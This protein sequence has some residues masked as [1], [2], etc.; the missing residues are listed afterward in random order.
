MTSKRK[1]RFIATNRVW[2]DRA[3]RF[4]TLLQHLKPRKGEFEIDSINSVEDTKG[5][6]GERG[7]LI[8]TNLR[9]IWACH[10][11]PTTNLSVGLNCITSVNIKAAS[12][13]LRG[14][15]QALYVMTKFQKSRFEFVF[16]SLVKNSPRMFTTVL[17]VYRSY[18]TTRLYRDL[19]L[20][21]AIIKQKSLR[22][23]PNEKV[24]SKLDGVWNLSSDQ[25]NLG[26]FFVTNVRAVWHAN[27]AENF[28][29]SIP[30]LQISNVRIR[31][32]KFGLALVIQTRKE[33]GG[34]ILGFRVDGENM[35]DRVHDE[36]V[37]MY[38]I[39]ANKPHFGIDFDVEEK[40]EQ[41]DNLRVHRKED[42]V[43]IIEV[44]DGVESL[45]AY[46]VDHHFK[47]N[48]TK[49][50]KANAEDNADEEDDEKTLGVQERDRRP[51]YNEELGLAMEPLPEGYTTKNLWL[52][53]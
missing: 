27:L 15:T 14:S 48:T 20:R 30:Y 4:D 5:N 2:E 43:E 6:N 9:L 53:Y 50:K 35:L 8:I 47:A 13:R 11:T 44:D 17:S 23:L 12:S 19:K 42:D 36:V 33:G 41:L 39:Y 7:F 25:G 51:V 3:L 26:T 37:S 40:P 45:A 32:S 49:K 46:A 24:Y 16:T 38:E 31:D 22:L 18:D 1:K 10:K 52:L 28:N 29:V 21:G 34:Y